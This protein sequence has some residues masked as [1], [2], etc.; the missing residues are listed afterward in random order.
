[1]A[2]KNSLRKLL[3]TS[4]MGLLLQ[5]CGGGGGGATSFVDNI[6]SELD[7]SSSLVSAYYTNISDLNSIV[8]QLGGVGSLQSVFTSP[9]SKDIENAQQLNTI[10][11]NAETLWSQSIA[12]IEAQGPKKRYEIYNS[13]DYK[14]AYASYLYLVNYVKPIVEKVANGQN[15]TLTEFNKVANQPIIN[16]IIDTEKSTTVNTYVETKKDTLKNVVDTATTI[17]P[18]VATS[19]SNGAEYT[20]G[21]VSSSDSATT[22]TT[23][24]G[25]PTVTT[26]TQDVIADVDNGNGT[27]TRTIK[28]ITTTTTTTPRTTLVTLVRTYTD[29]IYKDVATTTVTT[30][31]VKKIYGD[32]REETVLGTPVSST[33]TVKTFVRDATR[34]DVITV[35]S[36]VAD[37]VASTNNSPGEVVGSPSIITKTIASTITLDPTVVTT[38]TYADPY[39]E[40]AF[41]DSGE[42]TTVTDGTPVVTTAQSN[43]VVDT[44]NPDDSVTR[45]TYTTTVTTTTTPRT[46]LVSKVRTY[47]DTTK[48]VKTTVT[49]TTTNSKINYTDGTYRNVTGETV[50][51]SVNVIETVGTADRPETVTVS[52]ATENIVGTSEATVLVSTETIA[53]VNYTDLDPNLGTRT[54]G[55]N[56]N[57]ITYQTNEYQGR[58]A[59]GVQQGW[60]NGSN[61]QINASSAYSRGWTGQGVKIAVVDS[62]YDVD[63]SEFTGQIAATRDYTS[64]GMQDNVGHGTHVLGSMIAKKDGTGTHGVAY[65]ATAVV[66]KVAD[67]TYVNMTNAA[68]GMSWAA[69]Q[70]AVAGNLSANTNYD[71]TF[72]NN[73]SALADGTYRSTDSRY[74]YGNKVYYNMQDPA[75]WK[76]ATDK[77]MVVVNAAGNQGLAVPAN[78]GYF[79]TATDTDGNLLL[80]G[81]ML[82]VGAVDHNNRM[83]GFSN[84]AGHICQDINAVNNS[85]NDTYKVSDFY[86]LAPG[87]TYSTKNDGTYG[88]MVGTS[89]AAPIVTGGVAIVSQM[90]PYMKGE[91]LV[92]LLTTTACKS[93]CITGYN[94]NIHGS[95]LM[96]LDAATRPVG[97]VGIPTS[98]RTTSSVSSTSSLSSSG[99]SG[100]SL[101][102]LS[103]VSQLSRVMIVDEFARDFYVDM[104]K[105]ITV[106]DTRKFSDVQAAQQGMPYL[107]FQ[108][109]YG[110]FEQGGQFPILW[111]DVTMGLYN[112]TDV[113][114]DWTS[115]ITKGWNLTNNLKLKTTV[116]Y[117]SE[118]KTWLGN[119]TDGAL[120]VGKNNDTQFGQLGLEYKLGTNTFSFDMGQ[121]YTKLSTV[122]NSLISSADTL[123]TQSMKLGWEQ[124]L[125]EKSKWGITYSLPNRITKGGVNLNVPYATT[126][127]GEIVYDNVRAD[128]S[129]KTPEKDIGIFYS[130]QPNNELEWKTSFSLEYRQNAAGVAGDDKFVPAMQVS[131]KF[132]G[133]CMSFFGF[134]NERPG[135]QKMR[136]EEK[137]AKLLKQ[138]GNDT[139]IVALRTQLVD[140]DQQI[141]VIHGKG[142]ALV[143]RNNKHNTQKEALGWNK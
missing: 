107:S 85:C 64:T 125:D 12:L 14:E 15:I 106:K 6:V 137:L 124:Q 43:N 99:G 62:G 49:T 131:K 21:S 92:R 88:P 133:A 70:G 90:W 5:N 76:A 8:S 121:G 20:E 104:T 36:T 123:Q 135:C 101:S 129:S 51:E 40:T 19:V 68:A 28:R 112:S 42:T 47:T 31:R 105:S 96:D 25:T 10:V 26:A 66:V 118:Q 46:T 109:Q 103:N 65:D 71:P 111:E 33:A 132:Y 54:T 53:S 102:M 116:G 34:S 23:T 72:Y 16:N 126:L 4:A 114:G 127:D 32:A 57:S 50:T 17:D 38:V 59:E 141:A 45:N 37:A 98:G 11:G 113:K 13:S 60:G 87:Y 48:R 120:A 119:A 143:A 82:I 130:T 86:I 29:K 75:A 115:N 74:D 83:A 61:T 39:V 97:A 117:M 93:S 108:Q 44:S 9:N 78:P 136:A 56:T 122:S 142:T 80:G 69:D 52:T 67:S 35:S 89:M 55:Y 128:L 91:N 79:A 7:G 134:K 27:F 58:D 30:P 95:G 139:E 138:S 81:K 100:S 1:V 41:T 94:V 2:I 3:V 18:T 140:I 24:D 77:G 63:H 84:W 110:S 73:L 22:T